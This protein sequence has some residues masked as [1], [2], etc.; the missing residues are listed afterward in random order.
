MIKVLIFKDLRNCTAPSLSF[1]VTDN[2]FDLNLYN[3]IT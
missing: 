2:R 1:F 3:N